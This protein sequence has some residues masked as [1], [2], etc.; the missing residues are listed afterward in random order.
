MVQQPKSGLANELVHG[1]QFAYCP[2][3]IPSRGGK[4]ASQG[5]DANDGDEQRHSN[6]PAIAKRQQPGKTWK[7]SWIFTDEEITRD[8]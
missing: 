1:K 6:A 2:M 7:K 8:L 5:G 3:G 4:E